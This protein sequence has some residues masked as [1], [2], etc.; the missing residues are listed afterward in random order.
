MTQACLNKALMHVRLK[1]GK[2]ASNYVH[3]ATYGGKKADK[4]LDDLKLLYSYQRLLE[5]YDPEAQDEE[6][7]FTVLTDDEGDHLVSDEEEQFL[8]SDIEE[9]CV[10]DPH[11]C[12]TDEDIECIKANA[13]QIP[14]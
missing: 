10:P 13:D 9:G 1:A 8:Y 14:C 11:P 12:M 6:L 2:A 3:E 7:T 4:Y 5:L